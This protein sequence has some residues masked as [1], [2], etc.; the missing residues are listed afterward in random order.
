M[1]T[2]IEGLGLGKEYERNSNAKWIEPN[3]STNLYTQYPWILA[4]ARCPQSLVHCQE[5]I[6]KPSSPLFK[7]ALSGPFVRSTLV[8]GG[9]VKKRL[10]FHRNLKTW[11]FPF[12]LK[13]F[14]APQKRRQTLYH[15]TTPKF[16]TNPTP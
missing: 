6:R 11:A 4:H 7:G 16:L 14:S 5:L 2:T 3:F 1:E 10:F 12:R 9:Q 8:W 15:S 13:R